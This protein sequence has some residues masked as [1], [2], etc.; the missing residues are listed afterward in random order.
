[1]CRLHVTTVERE[2]PESENSKSTLHYEKPEIWGFK[3]QQ[4]Q[5]MHKVN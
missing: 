5:K 3:R 4:Q 1:M 2:N